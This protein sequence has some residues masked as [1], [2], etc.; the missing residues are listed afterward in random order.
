MTDLLSKYSEV[1]SNP[2]EPGVV[3]STLSGEPAELTVKVEKGKP[4]FISGRAY[5]SEVLDENLGWYLREPDDDRAVGWR[6]ILMT[7]ARREIVRHYGILPPIV[8]VKSLRVVRQSE[9]GK[10]LLCEI[11]EHCDGGDSPSE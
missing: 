2:P 1:V 10:A 4:P 11:A 6:C 5:V 7:K 8:R 9:S 3:L